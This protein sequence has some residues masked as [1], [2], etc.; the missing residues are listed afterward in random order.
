MEKSILSS[1]YYA[2]RNYN[3]PFDK[4]TPVDGTDL[5]IVNDEL[6]LGPYG[7]WGS[8]TARFLWKGL[9]SN[10]E[11]ELTKSELLKIQKLRKSI[12]K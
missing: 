8:L 9:Y 10:R 5:F 3:K 7:F 4:V 2:H 12:K 6:I 11:R 1:D